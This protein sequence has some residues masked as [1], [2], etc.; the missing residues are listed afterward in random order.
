MGAFGPKV[1]TVT[2][3]GTTPPPPYRLRDNADTLLDATD[4]V[5]VDAPGTGYGRAY[6]GKAVWGVD[7]DARTFA[8]FVQDYITQN[9]R[10]NSPKFLIGESYG[11]TRS[12]NLVNKLASR[13]IDCNGVV[14]ISTALDYHAIVPG[15]DNDLPYWLF[16][17]SYAAVAAYH[18]ALPQQPADIGRFLDE[19]RTFA[20]TDY[21]MALAQGDRLD[22]ATR[23]RVIAKL[24]QYTGL[25]EHWIDLANLRIA[26]GKFEKELLRDQRRTI[27][28][29]D[30]RFTGIDRDA[31]DTSPDYDPADAAMTPVYTALFNMYTRDDL[32]W[33]LVNDSYRLVDYPE[34][35]PAWDFRRS[36]NGFM[37]RVLAP[38]VTDDLR[39]A[40]SK[41]PSLRV[42]AANGWYDLATPF[43]NTEYTLE[44]MGLDASLLSHVQF[45]YYPSGHMI[46]GDPA[47]HAKLSTDIRHFIATQTR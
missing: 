33:K 40:L 16:L 24:H 41:N 17:P 26:P 13:G 45:T 42:L 2:N 3:A 1:V 46:Y 15:P 20:R 7:Q 30:A 18:H 34:V 14:L 44:H 6:D 12:A 22:S 8:T 9:D 29:L 23:Q 39:T 5:F 25:P 32:N 31:T 21:L 36:D 38:A 19:V 27:G 35:S 37:G 43:M 10:W 28:R 47:S 4:L 11:T